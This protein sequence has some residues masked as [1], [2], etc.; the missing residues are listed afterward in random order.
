[1][2]GSRWRAQP[3]RPRAVHNHQDSLGEVSGVNHPGSRQADAHGEDSH[4][5]D[6]AWLQAIARGDRVA[7]ERLYLRYH[8]RLAR[9]LARHTQR[10]DLVEEIVN[11]SMWVVWTTAD[12]FRGESRVSTWI[13]GIAW[14]RLMKAL[15]DRPAA[16][17][18][19]PP[20]EAAADDGAGASDAELAELRDWL[21]H[22]LDLL[23]TEQR[24][25]LELAYFLGQSCEE[26]AAIM[27]CA[28]GTVKARLF[29]ARLRLRN[30]LPALGG[31][32]GSPAC[33]VA[34]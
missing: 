20:E 7:F 32:A 13:I 15:R 18:Q 31:D 17:V 21:R 10:T 25:T 16:A 5:Q 1:L 2:R 24:T 3:F 29:H 19:S 28:V 4:A 27:D 14:R 30:S 22:G 34:P 11:E 26:I 9:F 23:P 6:I 12:R 8:P 33:A